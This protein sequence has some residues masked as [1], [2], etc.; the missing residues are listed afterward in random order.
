MSFFFLIFLNWLMSVWKALLSFKHLVISPVKTSS[1]HQQAKHIHQ[2][3]T[4][5]TSSKR[6]NWPSKNHQSQTRNTRNHWRSSQKGHMDKVNTKPFAQ[7]TTLEQLKSFL[8]KR[9]WPLSSSE[10]LWVPWMSWR[11][12][13]FS[14]EMFV[15]SHPKTSKARQ[16]ATSKAFFLFFGATGCW[17]SCKDA[18]TLCT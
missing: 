9:Q 15:R 16:S 1:T 2:R 13:G 3:Q 14:V 7:R 10:R 4:G 11:P 12:L 18:W 6:F 17:M 8:P 5:K